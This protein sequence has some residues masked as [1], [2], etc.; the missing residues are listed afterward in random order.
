MKPKFCFDTYG[1]KSSYLLMIATL[2]SQSLVAEIYRY[3]MPSKSLSS[4]CSR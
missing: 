3:L 4:H 2:G 1:H